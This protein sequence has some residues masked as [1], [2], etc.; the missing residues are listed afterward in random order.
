MPNQ[1]GLLYHLQSVDLEIARRHARLK[2]IEAQLNNDETI[3]QATKT[4]D[5]AEKALKPWQT[6]TRELE[7]ENKTVTEKIAAAEGDLYGG[8]I[9]SP[10]ALQEIQS[11]IEALKRRQ[12][13][14]EDELLEAM[15]EVETA[16][17]AVSSAQQALT[18]ARGALASQ[19]SELVE[20]QKHLREVELPQLEAQRQA[21]TVHIE[22]NNLAI[23]E[24]LRPKLRG[25]AVALLRED[26]CSACGVGQTSTIE[27]QV[28]SDRGLAFCASCGRILA[29]IP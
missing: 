25:Q 5:Q 13:Q 29:N 8:R 18:D 26:G 9:N 3:A 15:V 17:A 23:Y 4:L 14:L 24:K 28:R 10:K 1:A 16:Q 27:Q 11:E 7:L 6:R 2:A 12:S 21:E 22:P 20:E 19:Q